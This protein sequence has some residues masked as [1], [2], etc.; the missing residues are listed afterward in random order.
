MDT[1]PNNHWSLLV[2]AVSEEGAAHCPFRRPATQTQQQKQG[3]MADD[4]QH[5]G[6]ARNLHLGWG[7]RSSGGCV[8]ARMLRGR[9]LDFPRVE[10]NEGHALSC[11]LFVA[12]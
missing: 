5:T 8:Q 6:G 3:V 9:F 2:K 10:D 1:T 12:R 4:T 7:G 11:Q